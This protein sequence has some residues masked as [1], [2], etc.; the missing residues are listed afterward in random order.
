MI[1]I[2]LQNL[3]GSDMGPTALELAAMGLSGCITTIFALMAKKARVYIERLEVVVDATKPPDAKT[4]AE[5]SIQ[6]NVVTNAKRSSVERVWKLTL[7]NCP[8]GILFEKAG[9]KMR[10]NLNVASSPPPSS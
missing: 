5:A 8:V 4:V 3:G 7:E 1:I 9:V 10:Y 6:A 2:D